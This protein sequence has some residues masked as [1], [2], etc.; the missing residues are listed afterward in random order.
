MDHSSNFGSYCPLTDEE[1]QAYPFLVRTEAIEQTGSTGHNIL[2]NRWGITGEPDLTTGYGEYY[3][4][5][6]VDR[7]LTRG[8]QSR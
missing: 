7:R 4:H 6:F 1:L 8:F 2:T 3:G 5:P